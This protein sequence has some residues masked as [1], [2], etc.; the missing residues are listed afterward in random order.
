MTMR[1]S[2]RAVTDFSVI[3]TAA[4]SITKSDGIGT[5]N[6]YIFKK[7]IQK[8]RL[9]NAEEVKKWLR[10]IVHTKKELKLKIEFYKELCDDFDKAPG[11]EKRI[12]RYREEIGRLSAQLE[13]F[14]EETDR[15]FGLLDDTERMILTA[16]YIN[17][18]GW[19]FIEGKVYFSRRQAIRIHNAAVNRLVGQ[20]VDGL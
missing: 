2:R 11:F 16:R 17:T 15:I 13:H 19:D 5:E 6:N 10:G 1:R 18:I 9:N 3:W 20:E 14:I 8:M 4:V 7:G 12:L